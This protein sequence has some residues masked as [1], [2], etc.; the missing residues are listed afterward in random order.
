MTEWQEPASTAL[1]WGMIPTADDAQVVAE[2]RLADAR[3][4]DC[5]SQDVAGVG[6]GL[7]TTNLGFGAVARSRGVEDKTTPHVAVDVFV[8]AQCGAIEV[9]VRQGLGVWLYLAWKRGIALRCPLL[10]KAWMTRL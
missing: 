2:Q 8:W 5:I 3:L 10:P 6:D 1:S 7:A 4:S 9:R